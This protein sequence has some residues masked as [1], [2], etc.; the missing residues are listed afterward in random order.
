VQGLR[1]LTTVP[2]PE[3][4]DNLYVIVEILVTCWQ[5]S[6]NCFSVMNLFLICLC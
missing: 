4:V 2:G 1:K 6:R 5:Y 3:P